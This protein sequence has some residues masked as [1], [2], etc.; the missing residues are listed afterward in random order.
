MR[1]AMPLTVG[2]ALGC[3]GVFWSLDEDG[4]ARTLNAVDSADAGQKLPLF[5]DGL[6]E[7]GFGGSSC[8]SALIA[9]ANGDAAERAMQMSKV[10]TECPATCVSSDQWSELA[11]SSTEHRAAKVFGSFCPA[12][13]DPVFGTVADRAT[14]DPAHA[15]IVRMLVEQTWAKVGRDSELGKHL[16]RE[17]PALA[18]DLHHPD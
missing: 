8:A 3:S 13:A 5:L 10:I 18:A 12:S 14:M 6:G 17:I 9:G 2:L 16:E 11:K 15:V 4:V 7:S 1:F